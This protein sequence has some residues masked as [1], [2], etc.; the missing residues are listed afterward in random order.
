MSW[1]ELRRVQEDDVA[2]TNTEAAT[3]RQ[4]GSSCPGLRRRMPP[5]IR[6]RATTA[7]G[8]AAA[9]LAG[10]RRELEAFA[11]SYFVAMVRV[12]PGF[13]STIFAFTLRLASAGQRERRR[14]R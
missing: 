10:G 9:S 4:N 3:F 14:K 5:V 6:L 11:S 1:L 8:R 2:T 13:I 7:Y 12:S